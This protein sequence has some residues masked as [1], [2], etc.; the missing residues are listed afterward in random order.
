MKQLLLALYFEATKCRLPLTIANH[1]EG[2][3]LKKESAGCILGKRLS[4]PSALRQAA[5]DVGAQRKLVKG[6]F[7][8][9]LELLKIPVYHS[10]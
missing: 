5:E 8:K 10:L 9:S 1:D 6:P 3:K 4:L 2:M 7:L